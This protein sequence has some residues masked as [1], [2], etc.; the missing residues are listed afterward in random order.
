MSK[1]KT[2]FS[3]L[4][5]KYIMGL[6]GIFL[7]V[8]LIVH[9]GLNALVF[10]N[11]GGQSFLHAAHFMGTNPLMRTLEI[12]LVFGFL[13]HIADGLYLW[14]QNNQA[15]PQGYAKVDASKNSSWYSRSMGLLGTIL[16]IF[17]II[18]ASDF[19]IPNRANQFA[20]GEE[21]NLFVKMQEEFAN[22]IVV[23]VYVFACF[24]LFWHLLHGFQSAFQSMGWNHPKYNGIISKLGTAFAII[25]P[26]LFALMPIAFHLGMIR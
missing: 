1:Q 12:G 23:L 16:L 21:I 5:K 10:L 22:P 3:S 13:A 7:I 6:T 14:Y 19:W 4:T 24:S 9:C 18:H 8:F 25:V 15:R 26:L 17:L 20:T 11:D 2:L